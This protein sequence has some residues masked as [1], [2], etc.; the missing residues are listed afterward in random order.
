[1][2]NLCYTTCQSSGAA[3]RDEPGELIDPLSAAGQEQSLSMEK[4][5]LE[6]MTSTMDDEESGGEKTRMLA[7]RNAVLAAAVDV[8]F[9]ALLSASRELLDLQNDLNLSCTLNADE[10]C[11][12][13]SMIIMAFAIVTDGSKA[14][15]ISAVEAE[16]RLPHEALRLMALK[17]ATS[18]RAQERAIRVSSILSI[19]QHQAPGVGPADISVPPLHCPLGN[20]CNNSGH[21]GRESV[22]RALLADAAALYASVA[23]SRGRVSEAMKKGPDSLASSGSSTGSQE[24]NRA[25]RCQREGEEVI[26]PDE[27]HGRVGAIYGVFA[28]S[29]IP[30]CRPSPPRRRV[31]RLNWSHARHRRPW[32]S[33][34]WRT[35]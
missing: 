15:S 22:V 20:C 1:M 16:A 14:Q 4:L 9:Q 23:D 8:C 13:V 29:L 11:D 31:L 19:C 2:L 33:G 10:A 21:G 6:Q 28:R 17:T 34:W 24:G 7:E 32:P 12:L 35:R 18:R 30:A 3:F 27:R 26:W 5:K 25:G